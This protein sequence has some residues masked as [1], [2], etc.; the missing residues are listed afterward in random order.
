MKLEFTEDE[1]R[2]FL[3]NNGWTLIDGHVVVA[4]LVHGSSV[5]FSREDEIIAEKDSE[6]MPLNFAFKKQLKQTILKLK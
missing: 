6:Q 3:I 1:Q 5:D 4:Q 2:E